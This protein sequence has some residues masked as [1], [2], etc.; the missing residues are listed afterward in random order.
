MASPLSMEYVY[1]SEETHE[2]RQAHIEL[3]IGDDDADIY[4][5][6]HHMVSCA[7][8]NSIIDYLKNDIIKKLKMHIDDECN[9]Y[10]ISEGVTYGVGLT[11]GY[12]TSITELDPL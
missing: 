7:E 9:I 1:I 5:K 8:L 11:D 10:V 2:Y 12:A 4:I 6:P 3:I